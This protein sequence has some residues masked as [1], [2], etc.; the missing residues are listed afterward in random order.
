VAH[1]L[2]YGEPPRP[3]KAGDPPEWD[4]GIDFQNRFSTF[5][6][7][8]AKAL[9]L[10]PEHRFANAQEMLDGFNAAGKP[11]AG[12]SAALEHLQRFRKWKSLID[13]YQAY[14]IAE[15]LTQTDRIEAWR[16]ESFRSKSAIVKIWRRCNWDDE[17]VE[18]PRLLHFCET[19]EDLLRSETP[20]IAPILDVGYLGDHLVVVQEH[21]D[22][23]NLAEDLATDNKTWTNSKV[24]LAFIRK[25][26]D[27]VSG[28]HDRG[29]AHGDLKPTNLL[30]RNCDDGKEPILIDVV[31]FA[32]AEEGEIRT[33]AYAPTYG[34][35]AV[36]R[37]RYAVLKIAEEVLGQADLDATVRQH[38]AAA[39][40]TCRDEAPRLATLKP[41][42]EALDQALSPPPAAV[43]KT[44][45]LRLV[46]ATPGAIVPDEGRYYV[47]V[48]RGRMTITGG[49]E[50][51]NFK[52]GS[53]GRIQTAQRRSLEQTKVA[54]AEKHAAKLLHDEVVIESASVANFSALEELLQS[55]E[56]LELLRGESRVHPEEPESERDLA[57]QPM[58]EV[59][60]V[61]DEDAI[62]AEPQVESTQAPISVD[63]PTLWRTLIDVEQEQFTEGVAE[64][65]SVYSREQRRHI[66]P[67]TGSKGT[68]DFARDDKVLVE[69]AHDKRGWIPIGV[70]DLDL[71]RSDLLAVD[72]SNYAAGEVGLLCRA[73][74]E[75]RFR[76]LMENDS[77]YRRNA[78]T[79]RILSRQSEIPNLIDYFDPVRILEPTAVESSVNP[80]AICER[81]G[82]NSSQGNAF[83]RIW[84]SRP[85]GLLQGPP[86]TGKTKFI[87]AIVHHALSTEAV[88][89]VL[90]SSQSHEAVNNAAESVLK[91]FR[92]EGEEPSLIRVGQEG[93]VSD[94]LKPYHAE[95]VEAHY[96]EQFR[97]GLKQRFRVA[98]Q[99]IGLSDAFVDDLY[100]LETTVWPIFS[101]L[102]S[103]KADQLSGSVL[104]GADVQRLARGLL[105]TLSRLSR[106]IGIGSASL[107]WEGEAAYDSAIDDLAKR[108]GIETPDRVRRLRAV[109]GLARDWMGSVSSRGRS[110]EEFLANTRQIV[111]GTCVGLGRS[112]LGLLSARFDL[113]VIDEAARCTPSE[114][115]V[116]M[117]AGRWVVLVGDHLQ[118]EPFHK[119]EVLRE[120]QRR[121]AI[122][123]GEV[124]RGDF[125]RAFSSAYGRKTGE[126]LKIQYR[127]LPVIGRL[128]SQ[129]FYQVSGGLEHGRTEPKIPLECLPE[130]LK[131]EVLW[132]QTDNLGEQGFQT[133]PHN[134]DTSLCNQ[135]EAN[136]I[137]DILRLLDQHEPFLAWVS[138]QSDQRPVGIICTYAKQVD[139]IRRTLDKVSISGALRKACKI[140][141][142]D[143]Y[144][145][146]ENIIVILSLVRNNADGPVELGRRTIAQGYIARGNRIN[147]GLSRAMDRLIIVGALE[148]WPQESPMARVAAMVSRLADEG[149][150]QLLAAAEL[151]VYK[152]AAAPVQSRKKR[153]SK[154]NP[155]EEAR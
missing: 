104:E 147:V 10:A 54:L 66:V 61:L 42:T 114:L 139:L 9:N 119:P 102:R 29:R 53:D 12:D 111:C 141:T 142:I 135:A 128:V 98:A 118:L 110:F 69:F 28:F 65:D 43:R 76:S 64:S 154:T 107:E 89:N 14:P 100:F 117:Q 74:A 11:I 140:D 151:T 17:R 82:L 27:F 152:D 143:S 155:T 131:T 127:M 73:G 3:C 108:H 30:V 97:A 124:A 125:E 146:K 22:A 112:T 75:L 105:E 48:H 115:A 13:V 49:S 15:V 90:L 34:A 57:E 153:A 71:T 145:G 83:V 45:R 80:D 123:F 72:A 113:V 44:L 56:I 103:L 35:G 70:L 67:F 21:I 92:Q 2:I 116:P 25:L 101:H 120:T 55:P 85:L 78:A 46:G 20:G 149:V 122:P 88:R 121:T 86:G 58:E 79:S 91:L 136:T 19:A 62:P 84:A 129:V 1:T 109:A 33:S 133:R 26:A 81:Y 23:P 31:D 40:T 8:F 137:V 63:V 7:W 130:P 77:R 4:A 150:A 93:N 39:I 126:T 36:E 59:G 50:E 99:Q 96:R 94:L 68:I 5:H 87:G 138:K 41:L 51:L 16:S 95:K 38:L 18:A 144:Q 148:R 52:L 47:G 32:P 134:S 106:D 24:A 60:D 37:D 6:D 132:L